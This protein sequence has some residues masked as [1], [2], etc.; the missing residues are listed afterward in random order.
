MM[1]LAIMGLVAAGAADGSV[2]TLSNGNGK[3]T[4]SASSGFFMPMMNHRFVKQRKF[5]ELLRARRLVEAGQAQLDMIALYQGYATHY[6]DLWVGTP[7]PQ[8]QTVI[9]DT[10][11]SRTAFPCEGCTDCG[12][13][14]TG[15]QFHTDDYF[16]WHASETF[17]K[18]ECKDCQAGSCVDGECKMHQTLA[19]GSSWSAF[20]SQDYL[21]AGGSHDV[22]VT[23]EV[24]KSTGNIIMDPLDGDGLLATKF[25][26]PNYHFGCQQSLTGLFRTSL[27]DGIMVRELVVIFDYP[28]SQPRFLRSLNNDCVDLIVCYLFSYLFFFSLSLYRPR[29]MDLYDTPIYPSI[30]INNNRACR[31]NVSRFGIKCTA[32]AS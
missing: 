25:E 31:M 3:T 14:E 2:D 18:L 16:N 12:W 20:E 1:L 15:S 10:G 32:V 24:D 27:A 5:E 22:P 19:E 4:S 7:I 21:Y 28:V 23:V 13:D 17:K 6:V 11:S 26:I 8:R 9:V 30:Y 29:P